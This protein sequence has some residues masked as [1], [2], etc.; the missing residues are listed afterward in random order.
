VSQPRLP[1][2]ASTCLGRPYRSSQKGGT[3]IV[4]GVDSFE[5][6]ERR[7]CPDGYRPSACAACGHHGLHV[8]DYRERKLRAEAGRAVTWVVRYWCPSCGAVWLVLPLFLAR[9]LWRTWAVV[10]A[11]VVGDAPADSG[12]PR[13]PER[14]VRRW[15]D[16]LASAARL[17]VQVLA[18]SGNE[19]LAAVAAAV[20]LDATRRQLVHAYEQA[21][22]I[23]AGKCLAALAT[24]LH[25]LAP[26]VRLM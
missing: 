8:H 19:G 13:V 26:G 11:A 17:P 6:H 24:L 2:P 14:T 23:P 15:R 5:E 16:R 18:Q 20:G 12:R 21:F 22:A 7:V 3:L 25:R 4:E 10:E 1:P 9:W